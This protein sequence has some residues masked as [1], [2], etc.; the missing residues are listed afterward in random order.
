[1]KE[2]K[3]KHP[4]RSSSERGEAEGKREGEFKSG[5]SVKVLFRAFIAPAAA[6]CVPVVVK[7]VGSVSAVVTLTGKIFSLDI[8]S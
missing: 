5:K 1:M 2:A 8:P 6:R 4:G 7:G 3:P